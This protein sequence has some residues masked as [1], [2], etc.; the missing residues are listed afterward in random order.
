MP[1][2]SWFPNR[3]VEYAEGD[4]GTNG[5]AITSLE[6]TSTLALGI[7]DIDPAAATVVEDAEPDTLVGIT[8]SWTSPDGNSVSYSVVTQ[9]PLTA[10]KVNATTGVVR[11]ATLGVLNA[12]SSPASLTLRAQDNVTGNYVDRVFLIPVTDAP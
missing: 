10:F 3:W 11:V 5:E 9:V 6:Q 1:P 2:I 12:N 8:A 7:T 4:S